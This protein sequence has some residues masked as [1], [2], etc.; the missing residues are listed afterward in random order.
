MD[1]DNAHWLANEL[2]RLDC[3]DID[4]SIVE[5]NIFRFKFKKGFKKFD[6][7]EFAY[8]MRDKHGVL[9]NFGHKNE[10]LRIVTHRDVDRNQLKQ[11]LA[12]MKNELNE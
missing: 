6:H 3:I 1:H 7:D 5:T 2:S 12:A 10:A 8:T 4:T 11:A 9:M